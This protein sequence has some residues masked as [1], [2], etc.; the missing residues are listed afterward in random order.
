MGKKELIRRPMYGF[1]RDG[2]FQIERPS[3]LHRAID[4]CAKDLDKD[5][6]IAALRAKL[7]VFE[8]QKLKA[9]ARLAKHRAKRQNPK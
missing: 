5:A 9:K 7:A 8:D 1:T 6:I 3:E 2:Q 4:S